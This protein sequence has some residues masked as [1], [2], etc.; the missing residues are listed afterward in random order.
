MASNPVFHA[1]TKHIELDYHFV[2]EKVSLGSH[3]VHY[4]PSVDQLADLLTKPL[5]NHQ[6]LLLRT[7]LVRPKPPSLKG[8]IRE[9]TTSA[10]INS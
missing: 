2:W 8:D 3:H 4:V 5:H 7:K 9:N 6:H 1:R 10:A